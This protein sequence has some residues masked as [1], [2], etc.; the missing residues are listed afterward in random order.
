MRDSLT[1]LSAFHLSGE[2][3]AQDLD[4]IAELDLR[5]ALFAG[6]DDL[7]RL[8][9]DYPLVLANGDSESDVS[10]LSDVIDGML[11]EIAPPGM[12]GER[13]RQHVLQIERKIRA[14]IGGGCK[15]TLTQV[16]RQAESELLARADE[17][18][19]PGLA[20]SLSRAGAALRLDGPLIDCDGETPVRVVTHTWMANEAK[21][22]GRLRDKINT[23]LLKLDNILKADS[24]KSKEAVGAEV[25]ERSIGTGFAGEFDFDVMSRIL[26]TALPDGALSE[27]RRRR[28]QATLSTLR[29]QKFCAL[30]DNDQKKAKGQLTFVF[31]RCVEAIEAHRERLPAMV[32]MAKSMIIA[33]LEIEN[34]YREASHDPFFRRFD[35]RLPETDDLILLPSYLVCLHN[36]VDVRE[37]M[38]ALTDILNS[39]L[40]IKALV[41]NDDILLDP[42]MSLESF[43]CGLDGMRLAT[44]ALGTNTAFVL[45]ASASSLYQIR[46]AI[47]KGLASRGPALFSIYSGSSTAASKRAKQSNISRSSPY[48]RAAAAMDTRAVPTFIYDPS[49]GPDW[50]SRFGIGDNPQ[51]EAD[52]PVHRLEFEGENMRRMTTDIALTAVDFVATDERHAKEFARVSRSKWH[53]GMV[54]VH[55]FLDL[56]ADV[57]L[58]KVPYVLMADDGNGLHR[59]IVTKKMIEVARKC[60]A[61]WRSLQE[62]AGIKNSHVA[63]ALAAEKRI[64][65]EE[66]SREQL[67]SPRRP[68]PE[69][70]H[71]AEPAEKTESSAPVPIPDV[72]AAPSGIAQIETPRCTSCDEC[73]RI[74]NRMFAYDDNKQAYI[75]NPDAGTYRQLV[76]AAESCQVAIIHPGLPRNLNEPGLEELMERA[77]PFN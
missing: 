38:A 35:E 61:R 47:G 20:D 32:E 67:V 46:L 10:S 76:E 2:R 22:A 21:K 34:R 60:R 24:M 27:N 65:D 8:R 42:S 59:V 44:M 4:G 73:T 57:A 36:G 28:I 66:K 56:D 12:E 53:D 15:G 69:A 75:A 19:R 33:Q 23:L 3:P 68:A 72:P 29:T 63:R 31:N 39:D 1:P 30:A 17:A 43:P 41:Q 55:E 45:Q 25:L 64:R 71:P 11:H 77:K 50:A 52:W 54:P 48:L 51:A 26:R 58:A 7:S 37:E 9:Y 6:Y 62:L 18:A 16:W 14:L 49:V 70:L 74:N 13:L 5:P 40:P